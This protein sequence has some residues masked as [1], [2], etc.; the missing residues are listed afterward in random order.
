MNT[1]TEGGGRVGTEKK[2][3]YLLNGILFAHWKVKCLFYLVK[4]NKSEFTIHDVHLHC[5]QSEISTL[6]V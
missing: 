5:L 3:H 2:T 1:F 6:T 4:Q